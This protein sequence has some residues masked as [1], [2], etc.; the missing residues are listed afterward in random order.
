MAVATG[1]AILIG[2]GLMAGVGIYSTIKG[3]Q[4]ANDANEIAQQNHNLSASIAAE[5]LAHQKEEARKL[6]KQKAIYRQMEFKNPYAEIQNPFAGMENVFEDLKVDTLAAEFQ[7]DMGRQQRADVMRGL[8][9]AA[10]GSGIGALAQAMAREGQLQTQQIAAGISQQEMVNQRLAAQGAMQVETLER[11]GESA[12]EM[13]RLGGEHMLQTM[14]IDRQATL[15]GIQ[16]GQS[17]GANA[18]LQQANS[19]Q[20]AA[21]AAQ[22]QMYGAQAA[23]MYGMA[24]QMFGSS[25]NM[26]SSGISGGHFS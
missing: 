22:A 24:G 20:L 4:A 1:T 7:A 15:L 9:G 14:E 21:G 3:N 17:A 26:L 18:A 23:G 19:N 13:A 25:M 16:M 2:T 5:Q 11:Q 6:E 10:G 8:R 12:A